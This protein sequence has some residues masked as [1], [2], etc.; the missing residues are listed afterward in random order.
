[1]IDMF[2]KMCQE[3][4]DEE[5]YTVVSD[6]GKIAG[7]YMKRGFIFDFIAW[8]PIQLLLPQESQNLDMFRILKL[9]RLPRLAELIDVEKFKQIVN[10]YFDKQLNKAIQE[11]DTEYTYPLLFS[12]MM[13]KYYEIFALIVII[14]SLSYFFGTLWHMY[15]KE[16]ENWKNM[17]YYDVFQGYKT[18]YTLEEYDMIDYPYLFD[19]EH[20]EPQTKNENF[21]NLVKVWYYG[22]T[23]LSTIGYGDFAP[24]SVEEKMIISFIM[25]I[26]VIVFS[27]IMGN[28][29]EIMLHMNSLQ[30]NFDHRELTRWI[31]LLAKFNKGSKLPR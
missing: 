16:I 9:L 21:K 7:H 23:T 3:Y 25:M 11:N 30:F 26:G 29:I 2:L 28:L 15:I 13:V 24:K 22:L 6:I 18:F 19:Y 31:A 14:F 12:L 20:G 5:T 4:L 8:I 27:F 17:Q 10:E 1:M